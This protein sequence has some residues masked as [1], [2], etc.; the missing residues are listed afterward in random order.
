MGAWHVWHSPTVR[1]ASAEGQRPGIVVSTEEVA[2]D[3]GAYAYRPPYVERDDVWHAKQKVLSF[4]S[5]VAVTGEAGGNTVSTI[6]GGLSEPCG[7]WQF[8]HLTR[9]PLAGVAISDACGVMRKTSRPGH[10]PPDRYPWHAAQYSS[11]A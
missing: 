7:S 9:V 4:A 3:D 6:R 11:P 1:L 8:E 10:L 2:C 5:T